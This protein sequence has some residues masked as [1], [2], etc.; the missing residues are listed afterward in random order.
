MGPASARVCTST[1]MRKL[2]LL[3]AQR[4]DLAGNARAPRPRH[5][6]R[7]AARRRTCARQP[8]VGGARRLRGQKRD[9]GTAQVLR[10]AGRCGRRCGS[11]IRPAAAASGSC[12][13]A[14]TPPGGCR[15]HPARAPAGTARP[16]NC[17]TG[18]W[19]AS[20]RPHRTAS[21]RRRPPS[22]GSVRST[23][24]S[25]S[26]EVSWNSS[27]S[28][29]EMR[30]VWRNVSS[31][32][33]ESAFSAW[34][35]MAAISLWSTRPLSR[36]TSFSWA[37]ASSITRD[38]DA[39]AAR[40]SASSS[41]GGR[42]RIDAQQRAPLPAGSAAD[43]IQS[44]QR[45]FSGLSVVGKPCDLLTM[46]RGSPSALSSQVGH[47]L[48]AL[49]R[50]AIDR[51]A[52]IGR[53]PRPPRACVLAGVVPMCRGRARQCRAF[54]PPG[55]GHR[56]PGLLEPARDDALEAGGDPRS[57]A[58]R[59]DDSPA[60]AASDCGR[61]SSSASSCCAWSTLFSRRSQQPFDIGAGT[62]GRSRLRAASVAR[63]RG[64]ARR[65]R[66]SPP[67]W[68]ACAPAAAW[69]APLHA[70]ANRWS[71]CAGAAAIP[72]GPSRG[73]RPAHAPHRRRPSMWRGRGARQRCRLPV[74]SSTRSRISAA[75]LRVKVMASTCSG[76]STAA[77]ACR[78]RCASTVVLPEPAGA[79][80][81]T[82]RSTSS[83]ARRAC[84]VTH[85]PP[86]AR[87]QRPRAAQCRQMAMAAGAAIARQRAATRQMRGDELAQLLL[88]L[89][90]PWHPSP[91]RA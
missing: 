49:E 53:K 85:R 20:D 38:S 6:P 71:G 83:A 60:T 23:R 45:C 18:R 25:W 28:R 7:A 88:P 63:Q 65:H 37:A 81:S 19:T 59:Q 41:G 1:A 91:P 22:R 70:P 8:F 76:S 36:N 15:L 16:P 73:V 42:L 27:T 24:S 50:R 30:K 13:S 32:S 29:C 82:C 34:R 58:R 57:R 4:G 39:S 2:R 9:G 52:R 66:R 67:D 86:P 68:S 26:G 46:L 80:S 14:A 56:L 44:F 40:S 74:R 21:G 62:P 48:P 84:S 31:P 35:A 55:D 77:S 90:L 3:R 17:G 54:F 69:C 11:T 10:A 75:A 72:P 33:P 47:R 43:S 87:L 89:R 78:K 12:A 61:G 79:C 51:Q 64:T 5:R